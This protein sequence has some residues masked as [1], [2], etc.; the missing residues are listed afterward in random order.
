MR[1]ILMAAVA[2]AAVSA[3]AQMNTSARPT[4]AAEAS[5]Q[6]NERLTAEAQELNH[7]TRV[8]I[9]ANR[10]YDEAAEEA[11]D[12]GLKAALISISTQRKAFARGL[13]QR[14]A[15]IGGEPAQTGEATA[16]VY[17]S[18]AAL[19]GLIGNDSIAAA[20]EV[21]RGESYMIDELDE[22]LTTGLTPASSQIVEAEL[23][24]VKSGR[25]RVEQVKTQIETRLMAEAAREGAASQSSP[26]PG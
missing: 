14:V 20:G 9:D 12:A 26:D 15:A 16:A 10:L 25:D 7:L 19:R 5:L 11:D 23:A 21:Y 6:G 18:F 4:A 22:A 2:L 13:Q 17:R 24:R 3:C 8:A 1:R